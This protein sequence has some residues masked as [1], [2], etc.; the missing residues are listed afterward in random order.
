MDRHKYDTRPERVIV[1][2][3]SSPASIVCESN[4]APLVAVTVCAIASAFDQRMV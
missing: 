2:R 4:D 3:N 1:Q